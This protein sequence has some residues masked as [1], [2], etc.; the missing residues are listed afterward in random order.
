MFAAAGYVGVVGVVVGVTGGVT[1]VSVGI[2][3]GGVITVV[4]DGVDGITYTDV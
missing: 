1:D 4:V 3:I 2:L